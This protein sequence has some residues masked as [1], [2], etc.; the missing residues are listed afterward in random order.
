MSTKTMCMDLTWF[1][2]GA[3]LGIGSHNIPA[4][5]VLFVMTAIFITGATFVKED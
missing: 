3:A 2:L 4:S 1:C 5:I